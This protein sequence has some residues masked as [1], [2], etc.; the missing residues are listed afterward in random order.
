MARLLAL[1]AL[2]GILD[3]GACAE[4]TKRL[5]GAIAANGGDDQSWLTRTAVPASSRTPR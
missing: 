1:I 5:N 2:G 3:A 4:M